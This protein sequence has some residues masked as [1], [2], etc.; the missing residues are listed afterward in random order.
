M[1]CT[2]PDE[3]IDEKCRWI[4]D[5]S[6]GTSAYQDD[7]REGYEEPIAWRR[8]GEYTKINKLQINTLHLQF[9]SNIIHPIPDEAF[10]LEGFFFCNKIVTFLGG[11]NLHFYVVGYLKDGKIYRK[12]YKTP[13]LI[14]FDQDIKLE[15][16]VPE[17]FIIRNFNGRSLE[18]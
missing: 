13:E 9:R 17:D 8:L 2:K 1:I 4:V 11:G 14:L 12:V 15:H 5:L 3:F 7:C 18:R 16:E 6:D 10:P